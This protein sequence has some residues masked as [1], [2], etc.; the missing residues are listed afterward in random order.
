[1]AGIT[2]FREAYLSAGLTDVTT[3]FNTWE[4]RNMRY[5]LYWALYENTAY[6]NIHSWSATYRQQQALYKYIRGIYNPAYRLGEFWKAHVWGGQLDP[7]AGDGEQTASALPIITENELLRPAI[8]QI[9]RWSNW[10]INKNITTLYGAILG[11]VILQVVDDIERGKVYLQILHPSLIRAIEVDPWGN[12][13]GYTIEEQRQHPL[14]PNT[15]CIYKE[16]A[17]RDGNNVVFKTFL[18]GAPYAWSGELYEWSEPYGF[19]PMVLI[20]H[21]NVGLDYGWSELH[22]GRGKFQEADDLASKLSDQIR[23][24]VD[25]PW[26]FSGVEKPRS[27]QP[28]TSGDAPTF[29]NPNPGR[30]EIPVMYAPTGATAQ[31]L[32]APLDIGATATYISSILAE[33]ERD[34]PEL[35]MDIWSV[36]KDT[37]GR[38]LRAA[39]QRVSTKVMERRGIY[40]DAIVRAQMMAVTIGGMRQYKG[41]TSFGTSSY[42]QG[43]LDHSIGDRPIFTVDPL[44][45]IETETAFWTAAGLAIKAGLPLDVYLK[46]EGWSE[47]DLQALAETPE[48]KARLAGLEAATGLNQNNQEGGIPQE[49]Q[50]G[51]PP[52]MQNTTQVEGGNNAINQG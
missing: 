4:A 23:K 11:D 35:Q 18:N 1:M 31:P 27:G 28:K 49:T 40:D 44:D 43:D 9:W 3:D 10:Q 42:E 50:G 12:V 38:A 24:M 33:I 52:E 5:Q 45:D 41:F 46:R 16:T 6:R 7:A 8:S 47:K 48:Y 14:S 51:I 22:A 2:A 37:S 15:S 25:A 20:Q 34:Y 21:N 29:T 26:L 30:E 17:E 19:I 36:G 32:V 13:K 39:R